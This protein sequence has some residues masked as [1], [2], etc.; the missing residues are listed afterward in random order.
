M[1]HSPLT[2]AA[3]AREHFE[4]E[5]EL[6]TSLEQPVLQPEMLVVISNACYGHRYARP[7]TSKATLSTIVERPERLQA[8]T[9]GVAA[10]YVRLGSRYSEGQN[11]LDPNR[12][13][14]RFPTIPFRIQKSSRSVALSSPTVT[15]VHGIQWMTEL[16]KM[17]EK[18]E[19]KLASDGKELVR[20]SEEGAGGERSEKLHEGDLYLCGQSLDALEGALGAVCDGVDAVFQ[21]TQVKSGVKKAFVCIRPPGHHCAA[22]YPSGFCWLNNVHVGIN[23]ASRT[24]GLTHAAILDFDLHH[25]DG[26]QAIAWTLNSKAHRGPKKV[27][28]AKRASIGYFSMH[29]INSYPCEMGDDDKVRNASLCIDGAHGQSIWN[30]HLQPWRDLKEFWDHY[31]S[32]YSVLINKARAFLQS[33]TARLL[34]VGNNP[35]PKAAIFISAGFDASEWE[36]AGMQRHKVNVPTD[37]Y[38][39]FTQDIVGMA[40]EEGLAVDGRVISVLEGG[41]SDRALCSGV[42]SHLGGLSGASSSSTDQVAPENGLAYEMGKRIGVVECDNQEARTRPRDV[43]PVDTAW[44]SPERLEELEAL[45]NPAPLPPSRRARNCTPPTYTSVTQSFMAKIVSSPK[46]YRSVSGT[47]SD[48]TSRSPSAAAFSRLPSPPPP[49]VDWATSTHELFKLLIPTDRQTRSYKPEELSTEAPR[50]KRDRHSA[51][52]LPASIDITNPKRMVLR[53]RKGR[54]PNYVSEEEPLMPDVAPSDRRKTVAVPSM[55]RKSSATEAVKEPPASFKMPV[56]RSGRRSSLH[57][58]GLATTRTAKEQVVDSVPVSAP[59]HTS[60]EKA[61]KPSSSRNGIPNEDSHPEKRTRAPRQS[62]VG[63]SKPRAVKKTISTSGLPKLPPPSENQSPKVSDENVAPVA[64]GSPSMG[65]AMSPSAIAEVS[66]SDELD[67]LAMGVTRIKLNMPS[68][69]EYE[70]RRMGKY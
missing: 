12:N 56:A 24:Y 38:A 64:A 70:A 11:P 13:S 20:H 23:Y 2:A 69:E 37:F 51:I 52:G 35:Q 19:A 27:S 49:D 67:Q 32:Q 43:S 3:V 39:R 58:N 25:G 31:E 29:D 4:S 1:S 57:S 50:V 63:T 68:K 18:A 40:G 8:A 42:L 30:V 53:D 26:S 41:Y 33:T 36:G 22:T 62:R 60:L 16:K 61:A 14:K 5:L 9:L 65:S 59:K 55:M 15:D 54:T 6:H 17:C 44:W 10:A 66:Y 34:S 47:A 7:R 45:V 48:G 21:E 46:P 28:N